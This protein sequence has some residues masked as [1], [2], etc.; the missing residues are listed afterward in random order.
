[1]ITETRR[2]CAYGVSIRNKLMDILLFF[3]QLDLQT[4]SFVRLGHINIATRVPF[5][6]RMQ[7]RIVI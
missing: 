3:G 1:M 7:F 5:L 2:W 6:I 4:P